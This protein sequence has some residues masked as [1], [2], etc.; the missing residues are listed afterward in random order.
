MNKIHTFLRSTIGKTI[1]TLLLISIAF[2]GGMEYK[3]YQ[4]R[5]AIGDAFKNFSGDKKPEETKKKEESS[6]GDLNKKIGFEVTKKDFMK[7]NY[8]AEQ[9]FIFKLTNNTD[10]DIEGI[11]GVVKFNDIFDNEIKS[12]KITY[13]EGL[14]VRESKLYKGTLSYN[15]F[16]DD[17]VKLKQTDLEKLK[18]TFEVDAIIYTDGTKENI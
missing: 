4:I 3:S 12:T 15:E 5:S 17:D 1:A 9:G 16:S 2:F 7:N 13:D 10:K 18:Y 11:Q 8:F 6:A 14:V